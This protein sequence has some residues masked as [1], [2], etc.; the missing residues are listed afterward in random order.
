MKK[1]I[2]LMFVAFPAMMF[3]MV[4]RKES[5]SSRIRCVEK[6]RNGLTLVCTYGTDTYSFRDEKIITA[7]RAAM[8]R[9]R[10]T[11]NGEPVTDWFSVCD[12]QNGTNDTTTQA[13]K[14][15]RAANGNTPHV[16]LFK[17]ALD[18]DAIE[19]DLL[20][21]E[22]RALQQLAQLNKA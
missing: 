17:Q 8:K 16:G 21:R 4:R 15:R 20:S 9:F 6:E 18:L 12:S 10:F 11:R 14:R 1:M 7:K 2:V 19:R 3:G 22:E 5:S 13:P